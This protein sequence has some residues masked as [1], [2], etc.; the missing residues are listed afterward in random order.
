MGL[1]R[2]KHGLLIQ[3]KRYVDQLTGSSGRK[4][5]GHLHDH[6]H[7]LEISVQ[8]FTEQ[9]PRNVGQLFRTQISDRLEHGAKTDI[10]TPLFHHFAAARSFEVNISV[11]SIRQI[12]VGAEPV[13][14]PAAAEIVGNM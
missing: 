1:G 2:L 6:G 7:F 14:N 5:R 13:F 3:F 10:P 11:G 9:G 12:E 4:A 8:N